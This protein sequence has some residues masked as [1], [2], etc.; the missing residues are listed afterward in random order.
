M[1]DVGLEQRPHLLPPRRER[2]LPV[3]GHLVDERRRP[4]ARVVDQR[5]HDVG[6][7]AAEAPAE[8]APDLRGVGRAHALELLGDVGQ[9]R[10]RRRGEEVGRVAANRD[11]RVEQRVVEAREPLARRAHPRQVDGVGARV[12]ER[13]D[14]RLELEQRRDRE[15]RV[16]QVVAAEAVDDHA[17]SIA[18]SALAE[19]FRLASVWPTL[20]TTM[21]I[22]AAPRLG[23]VTA[24]RRRARRA[25]RGVADRAPPD[26]RDRPRLHPA[27]ARDHR[28]FAAGGLATGAYA[29]SL[30]L[31]AP[32]R[33]AD[34]PPRPD[35]RPARRGRAPGR[36]A[37]RLRGAAR[38]RGP[39]RDRR[40]RGAHRR[41]AAAARRDRPRALE[42][43]PRRRH[44]PRPLHRRVRRARG[45]LHRRARC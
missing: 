16:Q 23:F 26:G 17:R 30:G 8:L 1:A 22:A 43:R 2:A 24:L 40:A 42:P 3:A 31:V 6:D 20:M 18:D 9:R 37:D 28:L 13:G 4:R 36:G 14:A 21:A 32:P 39:A 11:Q 33:P 45:D 5:P 15:A 44:A 38:R 19:S 25:V 35:A 12:A 10:A 7:V 34:R 27:H 41:L 29:L